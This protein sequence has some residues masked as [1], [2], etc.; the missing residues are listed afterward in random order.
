MNN[1]LSAL[2]CFRYESGPIRLGANSRNNAVRR[3]TPY[4]PENLN[5]PASGLYRTL[6]SLV[7]RRLL[8]LHERMQVSAS[9]LPGE[10]EHVVPR[11]AFYVADVRA[12]V[13]N[14]ELL[15]LKR[16]RAIEA[17]KSSKDFRIRA[18]S[19]V[20]PLRASLLAAQAPLRARA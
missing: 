5:S 6:M 10:S 13:I 4:D 17:E 20:D 1:N 18:V 15:L 12:E 11:V 9:K 3:H 16:W 2:V 8:C 19:V 14:G 7:M